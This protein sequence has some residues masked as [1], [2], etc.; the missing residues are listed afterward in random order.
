MKGVVEANQQR[1][2]A[3]TEAGDPTEVLFQIADV[4]KPLMSVSAICEKGNRVIFGKAGG[5]V[6]N[7]KTGRL[8]PF[9]RE[10][11]IYVLSLWLEEGSEGNNETS[12]F[13]RR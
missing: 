1:L 10:N 8:I 6:Q 2:M 9:Q 13:T 4:S 7:V 5:V 12:D 11:G 3:M